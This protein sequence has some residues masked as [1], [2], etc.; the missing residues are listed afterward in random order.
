MVID[1]YGSIEA[2]NQQWGLQFWS[3]AYDSFEQ[4]PLCTAD[5]GSRTVPERHH[6]SLVI[7]IARFQND[8]WTDFIQAQATEIRRHCKHPITTNMTGAIG[9][10]NWFQHFRGLDRSGASMY[11]DL[12]FYHYNFMRFDRLRAEKAAPL[13]A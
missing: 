12:R 8:V 1:R 7:A 13:V 3:Q 11:A 5:V 4:I 9:A 6:P 2:L 10:M